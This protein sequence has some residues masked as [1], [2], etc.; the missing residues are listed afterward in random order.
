[1]S[2]SGLGLGVSGVLWGAGLLVTI[3]ALF[4]AACRRRGAVGV[5]L[6]VGVAAIFALVLLGGLVA[7]MFAVQST[8]ARAVADRAMVTAEAE[9]LAAVAEVERAKRMI[10]NA[11]A[12]T[13]WEDDRDDSTCVVTIHSE[14]ER[15]VQGRDGKA[16]VRDPGTRRSVLGQVT[17]AG[18]LAVLVILGHLFV[19]APSHGRHVWLRRISAA[20]AFIA[21]CLLISQMDLLT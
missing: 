1:M 3:I 14:S 8:T 12:K 4:V 20:V 9:S 17:G 18:A 7:H 19:D 11:F 15:D 2:M 13:D 16:S 10:E 5:I 6:G 21:V